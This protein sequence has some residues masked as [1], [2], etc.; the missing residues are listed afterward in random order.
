MIFNHDAPRCFG[1]QDCGGSLRCGMECSALVARNIGGYYVCTS[2]GQASNSNI[3]LIDEKNPQEGVIVKMSAIG[4]TT[5][6]SLSVSVFCNVNGVQGPNSLDKL[7]TCDYATV[8]RHPSG[9]PTI[10]SV[11]GRGWGWFVTLITIFLCLFGAYLLAGA[12]Y[13]YFFLGIRGKEVVP[14]LDFWSSLPQRAQGLFGSL[15]RRFRRH[16]Q[17]SQSSYSPVNF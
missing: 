13:R 2:I 9:C 5:K 11:H 12:V 1:C 3:S 15:V 4:S 17:G 7:G 10:I 6:C 16:P 8:L 14:N